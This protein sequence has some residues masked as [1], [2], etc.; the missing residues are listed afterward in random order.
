MRTRSRAGRPD[1]HATRGGRV[2]CIHQVVLKPVKTRALCAKLIGPFLVYSRKAVTSRRSNTDSQD[3]H[4]Q[5][6]RT[7][8]DRTQGKTKHTQPPALKCTSPV[9]CSA[10][11]RSPPPRAAP[12]SRA[13][14]DKPPARRHTLSGTFG[15]ISATH[16]VPL[17]SALPSR[18]STHG[19]GGG[20]VASQPSHHAPAKAL[21]EARPDPSRAHSTHVVI[22]PTARTSTPHHEVRTARP[23]GQR[24]T[25]C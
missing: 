11:R 1:R 5:T 24:A 20:R 12:P 7:A 22:M 8:P 15:R 18:G 9:T 10:P 23:P 21:G 25:R 3:T 19:F 17:D 16:R 6:P 4:S 14:L 13:Y 2:L